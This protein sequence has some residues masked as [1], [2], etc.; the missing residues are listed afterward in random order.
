MKFV[1]RLLC[2]MFVLI[3]INY[4]LGRYVLRK[5]YLKLVSIVNEIEICK[6]LVTF[7]VSTPQLMHARSIQYTIC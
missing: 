7:M 3:K 4:L 6:N 5:S 2:H 1:N